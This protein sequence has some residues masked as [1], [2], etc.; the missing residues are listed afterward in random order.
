MNE[1]LSNLNIDRI[2]FHSSYQNYRKQKKH[3]KFT[4]FTDKFKGTIDYIFYN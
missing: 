3:P 4:N 2:I 1:H